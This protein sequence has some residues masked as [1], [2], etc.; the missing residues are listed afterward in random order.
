MV[1]S[2]SPRPPFCIWM[3]A[4]VID[5]KICNRNF[6][7]ANCDF[8][9]AM[10]EAARRNLALQRA[11]SGVGR[12]TATVIPWQGKTRPTAPMGKGKRPSPPG[13]DRY[14]C[15]HCSYDRLLDDQSELFLTP[16][17]PTTTEV[18]GFRVPTSSYLHRGH[19]WVHLET[20][21][22]VRIGL[23]DF[24]Q[25]VLGPAETLFLPE[26]GEAWRQNTVGFDL[27]RGQNRASVL[28]PLDGVVEA[29]NPKVRQNPGLAHDDPYGEGWLVVVSPTNLKP[30]L[31]GLLFGR[32]NVAWIE[33]EAHKLL[34]L[35]ETTAG[36]TL[37]SGGAIIDDVYGHF[38]ELGWQ[39]LVAE[40]LH[41]S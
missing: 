29:V 21:G 7:C 6:D 18:F 36:V 2:T 31:E 19:T 41:T 9:R 20:G 22:R 27:S 1:A 8:D 37:P 23:D 5:Y 34:G 24:S 3:E 14:L 15:P 39:R 35:L 26:V 32:H 4:G 17:P 25:K 11:R 16:E 10:T 33:Q 38:P 30:D 40:F 12:K 28:A 13:H